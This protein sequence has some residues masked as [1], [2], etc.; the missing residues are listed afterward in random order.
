VSSYKA[1]VALGAQNIPL[2]MKSEVKD[3]GGVYVVTDTVG[4][5][6]GEAK[7]TAMLDK[8]TLAVVKRTV[9]QGPVNINVEVKDGK[10]T[11]TMAGMGQERPIAADLGGPLFADSAG[12]MQSVAALPLGE[13]YTTSYRNF[14]IQKQKSKILQ[15]KVSG[16]EQVTV[17]AG[18][19]DAWK[20][21]I[22]SG[23]GGPE[24]TTM[25]VAK[26]ARKTVKVVSVMPQ[27]N[28]ATMT[29]ELTQ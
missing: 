11:G 5:P 22:T 25:W 21:E 28:G 16:A 12:A 19:F 14:D 17:P 20:V 6:M 8:Q 26:D 2:T 27:M 3:E 4:T 23:E 1:Q 29:A 18:T 24:K 13:G 7:D 15:L 9:A 10:V